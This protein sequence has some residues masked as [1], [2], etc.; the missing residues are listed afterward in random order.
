MKEVNKTSLFEQYK[1]INEAIR[2]VVEEGWE[3]SKYIGMNE[4]K[5]KY[6]FNKNWWSIRNTL[7]YQPYRRKARKFYDVAM[8]RIA[9]TGGLTMDDY[10]DEG[11]CGG[12]IP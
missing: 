1:E 10:I 8:M 9:S 7:F 11:N 12:R 3:H 5:L 6:P 2:P 4:L